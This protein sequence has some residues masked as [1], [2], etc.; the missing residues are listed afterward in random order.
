MIQK[1]RTIIIVLTIS[2]LTHLSTVS[3]QQALTTEQQ[4]A[5]TQ[6]MTQVETSI[7]QQDVQALQS[8]ISPSNTALR[9]KAERIAQLQKIEAFKLYYEP[10]SARTVI[11]DQNTIEK[12]TQF[13]IED[14]KSYESGATIT[15]LLKKE[16]GR[17][18]IAETDLIEQ[19]SENRQ[20]RTA[21]I[22]G[23]ILAGVIVL[24]IIAISLYIWIIRDYMNRTFPGKKGWLIILIV[25]N[26]LGAI[27]Y[28]VQ[29]KRPNIGKLKK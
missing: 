23:P 4:E 17:W 16:E 22:V 14:K 12:K 2:V 9:S 25:L 26:F 8:I 6:L 19:L 7:K 13:F 28:Y 10:V 27:M 15:F 11:I 1:L 3:A 18:I 24:N 21:F 5:I 29:I 20:Q